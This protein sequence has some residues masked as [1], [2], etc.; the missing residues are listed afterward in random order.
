L[1]SPDKPFKL[2]GGKTQQ[3]AIYN[4]I[5][6][7]DRINHLSG[8][9]LRKKT[10]YYLYALDLEMYQRWYK[11]LPKNT[12]IDEEWIQR[13]VEV[14]KAM[15]KDDINHEQAVGLASQ[16]ESS[17]KSHQALPLAEPKKPDVPWY[18]RA[19]NKITNKLGGFKQ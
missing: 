3:S 2:R 9:D 19:L 7:I 4:R 5:Q 10:K 17:F 12:R 15:E 16:V 14:V 13:A 1:V 8:I 11:D 6:A 18:F